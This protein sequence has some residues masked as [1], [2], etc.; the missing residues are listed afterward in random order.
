MNR[1]DIYNKKLQVLTAQSR[2][3]GGLSSRPVLREVYLL[4]L[5][6]LFVSKS[7]QIQQTSAKTGS[8]VRLLTAHLHPKQHLMSLHRFLA[9]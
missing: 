9:R 1:E 4:E 2:I 8:E 7:L 6:N 5:L 3:A